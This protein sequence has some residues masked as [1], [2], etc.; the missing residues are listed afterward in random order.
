[1]IIKSQISRLRLSHWHCGGRPR[2]VT[3]PCRRRCGPD[4][5]VYYGSR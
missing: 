2:P 4:A 3:V 1:M 5:G